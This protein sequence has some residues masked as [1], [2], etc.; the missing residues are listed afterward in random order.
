MKTITNSAAPSTV[1]SFEVLLKKM[2]PHFRYYIGK[3]LRLRRDR[4]HD[5]LQELTCMAL[6][7]YQSL[8]R[9]GKE[10]FHTPIMK[11]AIKKYREGRRFC[12]FNSTDVLS[13]QTQFKGRCE[14]YS[15]DDCAEDGSPAG[16]RIVLVI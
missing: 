11:F 7:M 3:V 8:V 16:L 14:T 6:E 5:A 2:L 1:P 15:I 4:Y 13:H 9:R 10:V 12:G